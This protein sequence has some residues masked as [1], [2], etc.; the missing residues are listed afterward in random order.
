MKTTVCVLFVL[1]YGAAVQVDYAPPAAT[2][3][4]YRSDN[5]APGKLI[6]L[7]AH[8]YEQPQIYAPPLPIA[9][10]IKAYE[11]YDLVPAP[12]P[13][14]A[15]K[16]IVV[17]D[18]EDDEHSEEE[19]AEYGGHDGASY[20]KGD[21]SDYG[22]QHHAA[23]GEKGAKGYNSKGHHEEG[24]SGSYG[25]E[26]N[27]GFYEE[28]DGKKVA[29]HDVADAHGK[30]HESGGSYKGGDHG[31]KKHFSKGEDVTGYH[32]VFHKDEYKKDHDFYDVA[33]KSGHFKKHGYENKHHG[34]EVAGHKKGEHGDTGFEK[35]DHG[36]A[37][38]YA[39]GHV[40]D[41]HEAHSAEEGDDS[42]YKHHE[43]Y[44]KKGGSGHEKEYAY[45]DED[46]DE[47]DK[48]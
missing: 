18:A 19:S 46:D 39:K 48:E 27:E 23:H 11:A 29:H 45:G 33:D 41:D 8:G 1:A 5:G 26:H 16:P 6:Q 10:P 4:I 3:Y 17:E 24:K 34:S 40:D 14:I 36:K 20:E 37:G 7:G 38:Y 2:S 22:E 31:H 42:H 21:G 43:D 30:H 35:E 28:G 13:Y 32:K 9:Q 44:A 47:D 12:L 15:A 25:K